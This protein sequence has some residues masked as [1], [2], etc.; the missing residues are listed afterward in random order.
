MAVQKSGAGIFRNP[1]TK[2]SCRQPVIRFKG[3]S[4]KGVG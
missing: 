3:G 4:L 1:I 2:V